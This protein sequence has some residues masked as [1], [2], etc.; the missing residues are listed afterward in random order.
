MNPLWW[1]GISVCTFYY[2]SF[3]LSINTAVSVVI[4]ESRPFSGRR[5]H[6]TLRTYVY[7]VAN[8]AAYTFAPPILITPLGALSVIIGSAILHSTGNASESSPGPY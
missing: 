2:P 3:L 8:F 6:K 7:L 1:A 5:F 4:G